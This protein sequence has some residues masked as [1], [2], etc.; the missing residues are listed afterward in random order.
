[1][2]HIHYPNQNAEVISLNLFHCKVWFWIHN[3]RLHQS[4]LHT[5]LSSHSSITGYN[6]IGLS[7]EL[8][9]T[10]MHPAFLYLFVK[11]ITATMFPFISL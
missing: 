3:N 6:Q 5:N 1:M 10:H 11:N 2:D 4:L 7:R 9:T 8:C